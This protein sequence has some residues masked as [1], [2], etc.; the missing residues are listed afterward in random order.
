M[1]EICKDIPEWEGFYQ[2]ST[3]E[4]VRSNGNTSSNE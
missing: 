1:E 3:F 2:A 4:R